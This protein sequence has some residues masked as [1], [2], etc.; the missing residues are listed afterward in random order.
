MLAL[1]Q[2]ALSTF[3]TVAIMAVG[4][5]LMIGGSARAKTT[6]QFFF[7]RPVLALLRTLRHGLIAFRHTSATALV[8]LGQAALT[9]LIDPLVRL[10]R[11]V[12][13]IVLLPRRR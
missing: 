2:L 13:T 11:R 6:L 1:V 9:Y 3:L 4:F 8:A 7:G 12:L 10:T 5:A